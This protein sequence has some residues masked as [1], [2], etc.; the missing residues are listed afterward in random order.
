[1]RLNILAERVFSKVEHAFMVKTL[2]KIAIEGNFLIFIRGLSQNPTADMTFSGKRL[3]AI[4]LQLETCCCCCWVASVVSDSVWPHRRQPTRL[5]PSLGF[6][7]QEHWSGLPLPSPMDESEKWKLK[8]KSL[9]PVRPSATPWTAAYQVPLS[10]GFSR[11]E[12]WSE[13]PLPSP[14]TSLMLWK[15]SGSLLVNSVCIIL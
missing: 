11:Q 14:R 1:M 12:Y 5:P 7:R 13:V 6:S 10:M 8:V 15:Y 4:L 2:S 9:S 3:N